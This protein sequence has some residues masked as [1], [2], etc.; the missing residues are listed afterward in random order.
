[1]S[2]LRLKLRAQPTARINLAGLNP[3]AIGAL[4]LGGIERLAVG[5]GGDEISLADLFT[6]T[7]AAS[8]QIVIE[9]GNERIDGLGAGL[10]SGTLVIDGDAGA[11]AGLGMK[12]G[13][14]EIKGSAGAYAA[15]GMSGGVLLVG[16]NAGD[17][18]GAAR[19]G[20][21]FG[22]AGGIVRVGGN[23]GGRCGDRMRRGTIIARGSIGPAA[24]SRMMG[25]TI[26]AEG[27][28]GDG[29]GPLLRRGTLIA[30]KV[31]RL[32]P[33]FVD[34]GRHELVILAILGR[35]L[36]AELGELA[37][38]VPSG[39]VRRYAG[40]TSTIGKGELLITL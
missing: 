24:G 3:S 28:F 35:Y 16:G 18:L 37:P 6:V 38:T 22:M 32:L 4:S 9:G 11:Y 33:T 30:P 23:I 25:G 39:P 5:T 21:K 40:D 12:G 14:L 17:S 34:C 29:P 20:E 31:S 1:M 27:G 10:A 2:V 36:K 13:R 19:T 7:G 15:S 26:W 8:D